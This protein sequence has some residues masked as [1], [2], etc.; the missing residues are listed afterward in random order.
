MEKNQKKFEVVFILDRSGSMGGKESDTIGGF[1]ST[2]ASQKKLKG[3]IYI[4]TVLFDDEVEF[5]HESQNIKEVKRITNKDYFVRGSTA[6]WDAVGSTIKKIN[7]LQEMEGK[8]N[9]T[10]KT[11]C[12]IITDGMENASTEYTGKQVR[13]LIKKSKKNNWEFIFMG[14]NIE[15]EK[16]AEELGIDRDMAVNYKNDS[17]GIH[18]NFKELADMCC[19]LNMPKED[20]KANW[21]KAKKKITEH[22]NN[23]EDFDID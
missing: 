19:S 4:T 3:D 1:N 20:F 18:R 2:L 15:S 14:A 12:V 11:L 17:E 10:E 16:V 21:K 9:I 5:L 6:M 7:H 8:N 23:S 22:Y 13:S